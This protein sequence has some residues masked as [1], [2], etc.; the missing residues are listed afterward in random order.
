MTM[1]ESEC[2]KQ[3]CK[4]LAKSTVPHMFYSEVFFFYIILL[5]I[6]QQGLK[7]HQ[8]QPYRSSILVIYY[9]LQHVSAVKNK[10]N[11]Y[12]LSVYPTST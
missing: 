8:T 4:E 10:V 11:P 3:L 7:Y 6:S 5:C 9:T 2:V 1:R 12:I